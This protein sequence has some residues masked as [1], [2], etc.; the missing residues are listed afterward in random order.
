[1][2]CLATSLVAVVMLAELEQAML[3]FGLGRTVAPDGSHVDKYQACAVR[4][5]W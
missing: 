1:V 4:A 3:R 5:R 2:K